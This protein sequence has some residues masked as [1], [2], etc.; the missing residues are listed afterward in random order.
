MISAQSLP[1]LTGHKV[2]GKNVFPASLYIEMAH[3]AALSAFENAPVQ[4]KNM[5][6][7]KSLILEDHDSVIIQTNVEMLGQQ[8][9]VFQIFS[10]N[11]M[12]PSGWELN[13]SGEVG[14]RN[15]QQLRILELALDYNKPVFSEFYLSFKKVGVEYEELFQHTELLEVGND[16]I[17][18][19]AHLQEAALKAGK[20]FTMNPV[21]LDQFIQPVFASY[22]KHTDI[23]T[24][25]SAFVQ[26]IDAFTPFGNIDNRDTFSVQIWL[27]GQVNDSVNNIS[28][29][30]A[31]VEVFSVANNQL[32][33]KLEGVRGKIID[34]GIP[35]QSS[36]NS[37]N[38]ADWFAQMLQAEDA[39][40]KSI[41]QAQII[42]RVAKL[43][44]PPE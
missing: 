13:C 37:A 16:V 19:K 4:V 38:A 34:L 9:A 35:L 24:Q 12:N 33:C 21:L 1:I 30:N 28:S 14:I 39:E 41:I 27:H 6:F 23:K 17:L 26:S 32:I 18:A 29:F 8:Q 5:V 25:Q 36:D 20:K 40:R 31:E 22:L 43:I 2:N 44:K 42:Q 3:S 11:P 15:P 10:R 7:H